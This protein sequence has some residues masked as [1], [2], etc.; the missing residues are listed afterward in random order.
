MAGE[1]D[2]MEQDIIDLTK[3]EDP[4]EIMELCHALTVVRGLLSEDMMNNGHKQFVL[5]LF[6]KKFVKL[7]PVLDEFLDWS[8]QHDVCTMAMMTVADVLNIDYKEEEGE[9]EW[10]E[11]R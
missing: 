1:Q 2:I 10:S 8:D 4:L 3:E 11:D 9:L 7:Q 5:T 6:V